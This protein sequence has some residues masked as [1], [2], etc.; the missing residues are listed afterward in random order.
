MIGIT[1]MGVRRDMETFDVKFSMIHQAIAV[2]EAGLSFSQCLHFSS[3][4]NHPCI[5]FILD[6][7]FKGGGPV[8]DFHDRTGTAPPIE[9]WLTGKESKQGGNAIFQMFAV[10]DHIQK[11]VLHDK[12]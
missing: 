7:I 5:E 4:Q 12:L 8:F 6:E 9:R 11:T 10:N 3:G 1:A 2:I